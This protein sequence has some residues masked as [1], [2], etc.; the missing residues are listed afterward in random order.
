MEEAANDLT[1]ELRG[2]IG[3][4]RKTVSELD[5]V[6]TLEDH[7]HFLQVKLKT[8]TLSDYVLHILQNVPDVTIAFFPRILS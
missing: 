8:T 1:E 6:S 5:G 7:I 2:E 3:E 4:L